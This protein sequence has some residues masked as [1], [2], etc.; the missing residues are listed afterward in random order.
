MKVLF[1]PSWYPINDG[2]GQG[3]ECCREHVRSAALYDQVAVLL[4]TPRWDR[5]PTLHWKKIDDAGVP[6]FYARYGQSPIPKTSRLIFYLSLRRAL[7]RVIQVWGMPDI[8]HTQDA[9]AYYAIKA[10]QGIGVPFVMSQHWTCFVERTITR[11]ELKRFAWAFNKVKRVLPD[12]K[13]AAKHYEVYGL[14]PSVRWLPNT[15]DTEIFFPP[16]AQVRE[17]WLLHASGLTAQKRFPDV[18]DAF[19]R[20]RA[21]RP[22]VILHIAG[23][24]PNRAAMETLARRT[25]PAGSVHFHGYLSKPQLADLMRQASGF[26]LPSSAENLPC[27]LI[28]ALA[29]GCPVLSTRVGGI[30]AL[31]QE[32]KGILVDVGNIEQIATGM[33]RL[34]NDTHGFD[35]GRIGREIRERYSHHAVGRILHEEYSK[36][37]AST[38]DAAG[39]DVRCTR[40]DLHIAGT[41]R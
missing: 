9:Q 5:W 32:D 39:N 38:R 15:V 29:C 2:T 28:E 23:D 8:I 26:I 41:T 40:S 4:V 20:V 7:K 1:V 31:V 25:L 16:L 35:M 30:T 36:A 22:D 19:A 10:A 6:T 11:G 27:V 37:I 14:Q 13:F 34:L 3:G 18:I 21:K 33:E 17:P 24:G 12:N